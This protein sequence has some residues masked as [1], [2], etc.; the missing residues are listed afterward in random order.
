M[1]VDDLCVVEFG[2]DLFWCGVGG[3]IEVFGSDVE[4]LV[5]YVVFDYVGLVVGLLEDFD[6]FDGVLVELVLV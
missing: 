2:V 5:V 6:D 3:D 1:V 4:Y